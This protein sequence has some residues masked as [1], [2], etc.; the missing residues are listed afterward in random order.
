MK[1][2]RKINLVGGYSN[3]ITLPKDWCSANSIK[4]GDEVV[5][6]I[7]DQSIKVSPKVKNEY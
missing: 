4:E 6:E 7:N 1:L 2:T 5:L 3:A